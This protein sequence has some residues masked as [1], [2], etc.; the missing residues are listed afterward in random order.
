MYYS[1]KELLHLEILYFNHIILVS[2]STY[3]KFKVLP[4]SSELFEMIT[5]KTME[6]Y[7]NVGRK[8]E[9]ISALTMQYQYVSCFL[10][11]Q[12]DVTSSKQHL[13]TESCS[14]LAL[15]FTHIDTVNTACL[16]QA[17]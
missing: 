13:E 6:R 14:K 17:N 10:R 2:A 8:R 7:P 16:L 5:I 12:L 15:I 4:R 3:R 9:F 11:S 1:L